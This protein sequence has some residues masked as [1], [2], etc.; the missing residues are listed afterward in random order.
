MILGRPLKGGHLNSP[1]LEGHSMD[2][3]AAVVIVAASYRT[4]EFDLRLFTKKVGL[5]TTSNYFLGG[6]LAGAGC[7]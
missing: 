1:P 4:P 7:S 3:P 6:C 2:V 5:R